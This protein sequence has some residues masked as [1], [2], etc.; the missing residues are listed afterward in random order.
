MDR[1]KV[2]C[3]VHD[4]DREGFFTARAIRAGST[5]DDIIRTQ[6]QGAGHCHLPG[7]RINGKVAIR[8]ADQ[9]V[10]DTVLGVSIRRETGQADCITDQCRLAYQVDAGIAVGDR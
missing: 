6:R 9:L 3:C 4:L 7:C 8:V 10:T 1:G 2:V 5:N